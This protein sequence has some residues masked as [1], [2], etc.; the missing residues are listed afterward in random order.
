MKAR[1]WPAVLSEEETLRQVVEEGRSLAR[2]GD[3]EFKLCQGGSIK[4]QV[5]EPTLGKRLREILL[6]SGDCLVGIPNLAMPTKPFW[7]QFRVPKITAFFDMKRVYGSAFVSRPDSAPWIHNPTYWKNIESL[8]R[9]RNVT[10]VR[11]S[12]KSLTAA[13]LTPSAA[14]VN[15]ILCPRQNAWAERGALLEQIGRPERVLLCC[16]P[17]ATVLAA[18]LAAIG[19][20]A[21]DLGHIGMWFKRLDMSAEAALQ[22]GRA[23]QV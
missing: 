11:G 21:I 16:G 20:Q 15:E 9:G 23:E 13:L 12:G 17:T 22:A 5:F 18:D 8:W 10:L 1:A 6:S 3:G 19:V 7:D 4:S 2:Y 14:S